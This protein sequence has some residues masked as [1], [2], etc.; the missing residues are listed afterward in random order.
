MKKFGRRNPQRRIEVKED[1]QAVVISLIAAA[2]LN[3]LIK[4]LPRHAND[5][6]VDEVENLKRDWAWMNA[7]SR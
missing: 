7:L 1:Q 4:I 5:I 3:Q 2:A 6:S